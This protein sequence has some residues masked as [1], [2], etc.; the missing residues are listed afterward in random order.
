MPG[1]GGVRE[2]VGSKICHEERGRVYGE[3]RVCKRGHHKRDRG[4]RECVREGIVGVELFLTLKYYW[5]ALGSSVIFGDIL[6]AAET[7]SLFLVAMSPSKIN[8]LFLAV[9]TLFSLAFLDVENNIIFY[10]FD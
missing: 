3:E 1:C 10:D 4:E 9:R 2:A 7:N 5:Q 6:L 8:L